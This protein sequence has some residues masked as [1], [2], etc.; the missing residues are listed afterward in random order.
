MA[1]QMHFGGSTTLFGE[2]GCLVYAFLLNIYLVGTPLFMILNAVE[3]YVAV[4]HPL[5]LVKS[6]PVT[7]LDR[8]VQN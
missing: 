6:Y 1:A 8:S 3:R 5:E 4:V 7:W 2:A